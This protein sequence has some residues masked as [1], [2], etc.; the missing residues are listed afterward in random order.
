VQRN[1]AYEPSHVSDAEVLEFALSNLRMKR[2]YRIIS[3]FDCRSACGVVGG[4]GFS[5]KVE[6]RLS[7]SDFIFK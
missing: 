7:I 4:M 1:P 6:R 3:K 2:R 5:F